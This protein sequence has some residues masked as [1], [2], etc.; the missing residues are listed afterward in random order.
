MMMIYS[1]NIRQ[2]YLR[3][4]AQNIVLDVLRQASVIILLEKRLEI[5]TQNGLQIKNIEF[6]DKI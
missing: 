3:K 6:L 2:K 5:Y 1:Y 4:K